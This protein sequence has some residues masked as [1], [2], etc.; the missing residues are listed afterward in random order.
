L[1][2]GQRT[3]NSVANIFKK[4]Q[5]T[6]EGVDV[7]NKDNFE[8]LL[9]KN[10]E[11]LFFKFRYFVIIAVLS[12]LFSSIVLFFLG[13]YETAISVANFISQHNVNILEL[14]FIRSVD[15]F[16]FGLI[17][18]IFSMGTYDLF[19]SKLDPAD[20]AGIR[21]DWMHFKNIDELK[22]ALAKVVII[23]LIIEFFEIVLTNNSNL[24]YNF[25]VVPIGILVIA[26]AL[27][28]LR[29]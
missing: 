24:T 17:M 26:G 11:P 18:L 15:L 5:N 27:R 14:G 7:E 8:K 19:V 21:P 16:L 25:L 1:H 13:A 10:F 6:K 29:E 12:T 9:D 4:L 22:F 20:I 23:I 3:L 2:R 28:L